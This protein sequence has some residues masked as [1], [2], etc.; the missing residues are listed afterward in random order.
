MIVVIG[1][2]LIDLIESKAQSGSYQAVVGGAN[3]N[4]AIALARA[5][6]SQQLL[7]RIS[8]DSFGQKIR[9]RLEDNGVGLDY[10]IDAPEATSLAIASIGPS[11]G[12]KYSFYVE[13][14]ADW[15]FT[16][17]ELPTAAKLSE[18]GAKALQFGCL[19]MALGPGNKVIEAWAAEFFKAGSLTLSHDINVRPAL[20][21]D[22]AVE[23]E[24]VERIN[25][26]SHIV[27]ASDDDINWLYGLQAG[28]NVDE[29]AWGWIG[30]SEQIVFV[31]RGA[32][33]VSIYRKD[34]TRIDV[35]SRSVQV[36]DTVGSGD[37]FCAHM[38]SGL[39]A[40]DAL[41]EAPSQK[42]AAVT[43]DQLVQITKVAAIAASITCERVGAEPPTSQELASVVAASA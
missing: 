7:A 6:T 12:A 22:A 10:A 13:G 25:S 28:S 27:K 24:R 39:L 41:G 34:R 9:T 2:A 43:N 33:G 11:G 40:I 29:I 15:N 8:S 21:F 42:L 30:A 35:P 14:T 1:E 18:I 23:K 4:V 31:T 16:R 26:I 20:G 19:T 32:D 3:A 36:Q 38:L 17:E 5:G 37:T